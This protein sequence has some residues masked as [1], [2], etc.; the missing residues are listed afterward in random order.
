MPA[1]FFILVDGNEDEVAA[2][3]TRSRSGPEG[4]QLVVDMLHDGE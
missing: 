2:G 4:D 3:V 1:P